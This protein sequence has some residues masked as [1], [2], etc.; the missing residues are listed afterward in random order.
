MLQSLMISAVSKFNDFTLHIY[1]KS[2]STITRNHVIPY[3]M[4]SDRLDSL[5][6]GYI[7]NEHTPSLKMYFKCGIIQDTVELLYSYSLFK[8]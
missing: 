2:L 1:I 3:T 6:I 8:F 4:S 7:N 5:A